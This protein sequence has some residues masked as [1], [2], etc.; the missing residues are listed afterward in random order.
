MFSPSTFK[1]IDRSGGNEKG[2]DMTSYFSIFTHRIG[3][4]LARFRLSVGG[5]IALR[6]FDARL[7]KATAEAPVERLFFSDR[8]GGLW[9]G[10]PHWMA[11]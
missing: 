11:S 7:T 6:R 8:P 5:E 9:W 1:R 10:R 2:R 3:E 4:A